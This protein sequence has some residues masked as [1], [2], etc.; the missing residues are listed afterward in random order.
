MAPL[1][2]L[3]SAWLLMGQRRIVETR[4]IGGAVEMLWVAIP[5]TAVW[6]SV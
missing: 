2:V 5:D 3:G 4:T 6:R 1:A